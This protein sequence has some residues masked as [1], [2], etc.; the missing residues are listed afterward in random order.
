MP[1]SKLRRSPAR[2]LSAIGF[3]CW[4][5]NV[6]SP[7]ANPPELSNAPNCHGRA[8][9]QKKQKT[10]I[11]V[12]C[13]KRSIEPAEVVGLDKRVFV[14]EKQANRGDAGPCGPRESEACGKPGEQR[15]DQDVHDARDP[16][17]SGDAETL[18]NRV[19]TCAAVE[20]HILAGIEHIE[21]ADPECYGGAEKQ[22]ARV[23]AAR[24]RGPSRR[25]GNAPARTEGQRRPR[26]EAV[27]LRVEG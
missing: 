15:N 27:G 9:E 22:H 7:I 21:T 13:E 2:T 16:E 4:S 26:R 24:D 11:A 5:L 19:E 10:N 6:I 14:T 12:H 1:S 20:L 8:P 23:E 18:R 3:R 25:R 17:G